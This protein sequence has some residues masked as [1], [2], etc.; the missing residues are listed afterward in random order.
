MGMLQFVILIICTII[1]IGFI[2]YSLI[3]RD[4]KSLKYITL[5]FVFQ[6]LL[7][8]FASNVFP[9]F[10]NKYYIGYKEIVMLG[11][12]FMAILFRKKIGKVEVLTI[13]FSIW[14]AL[15]AM[16][17]NS[18]LTTVL[19][20]LRQLFIPFILILYGYSLDLTDN[21]IEKYLDFVIG[22]GIWQAIFGVIERFI[23]GDI[24]WLKLNIS[25]LFKTKGFNSWIMSNLPGNYY[26]YDLYHIL[27]IRIRRL[28]G[29]M[30]DPLLTSHYLALCLVL[31][32]F[33]TKRF[34]LKDKLIFG[35]MMVACILT[36]SKGA[37][38]II[39]FGVLVKVYIKNKDLGRLLLIVGICT[40]AIIISTNIFST[41]SIHL[42]GI[43]SIIQYSSLIGYGIG[44]AGNMAGLSGTK[45]LSGESYMGMLII[46][47][48]IIGCI[49]FVAYIMFLIKKVLKNHK[50]SDMWIGGVAF[51]IGALLEAI[52]SESAISFVGS[53]YGFI[54]LGILAR[55]TMKKGKKCADEN[56]NFDFS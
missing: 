41:V 20:C 19:V 28:V 9:G 34:S 25:N 44:T 6:N 24:F 51:V 36:L 22:V 10:L 5:M 43:T 54:I 11:V 33:R 46:Q 37:I 38:L 14:L 31:M 7:S 56:G 4:L 18:N 1:S 8:L 23:L 55:N 35:T 13:I 39:L 17:S 50:E 21:D 2:P 27:G 3:K 42:K 49:M 30:T 45:T 52:V 29:I 48:G 12:I 53:G 32:I 40:L 15:E 26:S 47:I 16:R